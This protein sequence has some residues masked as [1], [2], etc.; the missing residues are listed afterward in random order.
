MVYIE[1]EKIKTDWMQLLQN[2]L[3]GQEVVILQDDQPVL[4][5][6]RVGEPRRYRGS[7]KGQIIMADDFDEPLAE[8]AEYVA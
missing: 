7:A 1:L 2:A 8:F 5:I 4:K 6:T 3:A